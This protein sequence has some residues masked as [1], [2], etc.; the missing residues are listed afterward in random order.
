MKAREIYH[1]LRSIV[2]PIHAHDDQLVAITMWIE[3][4]FDYKPDKLIRHIEDTS[5]SNNNKNSELK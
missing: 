2:E 4:E 1:A 5:N 3:S